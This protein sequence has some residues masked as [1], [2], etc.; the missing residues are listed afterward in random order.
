MQ[1]KK[2]EAKKYIAEKLNE[3]FLSLITID[4]PHNCIATSTNPEFCLNDKQIK[5]TLVEDEIKHNKKI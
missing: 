5:K 3:R 1:K 4:N 2:K